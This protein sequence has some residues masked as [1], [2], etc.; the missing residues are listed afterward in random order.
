MVLTVALRQRL[1]QL[2]LGSHCISNEACFTGFS[3]EASLRRLG[4]HR[5]TTCRSASTADSEPIED[6]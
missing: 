4:F 3:C 6:H 5:R 1:N 2:S